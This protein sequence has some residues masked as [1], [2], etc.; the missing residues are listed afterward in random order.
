LGARAYASSDAPRIPE[1][2]SKYLGVIFVLMDDDIDRIFGDLSRSEYARNRTIVEEQ[3]CRDDVCVGITLGS[4]LRASEISDDQIVEALLETALK[5]SPETPTPTIHP[6]DP[7]AP[8]QPKPAPP[9][10]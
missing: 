6:A 2:P 5:L 3:S 8:I 7:A 10:R 1:S 4:Y 9:S